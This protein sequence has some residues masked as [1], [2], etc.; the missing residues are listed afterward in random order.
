MNIV[1]ENRENLTALITVTVSEADYTEAVDKT[2]REYKRKANIP[3]FRPGMVPMG[4]INK[5][6]RRGAVAEESYKIANKACFDFIEKEKIDFVGD[7]LPSDEQKPF[8]FDNDKEHEFKFELGLAPEVNIALSEKDKINFLKITVSD[9][10]R[11][12]FRTNY[13]RRFG[14]LEDVESV[15]GDEAL[16]VTLDNGTVKVE[17]AYVGLVSMGEAERSLFA[18]RK[19]GDQMDVD[20]N[21]LYTN[22]AQRAAILRV[23]EDE[24]EGIDPKFKLTIEKIRRFVEP[25][26]NEEFFKMAFPGGEVSDEKGFAAFVDGQISMDLNRESEW[27][28][29]EQ[30]KKMLLDKAALKMPAEFLKK[31]LFTIN[32]G[33]FSMEDIEKDFDAFLQM[34]TWN[35]IQKHYVDTLELKLTEEEVQAEAKALAAMQFAQYGMPQVPEDMLANYAE[36]ILS[37]REEARKITEKLYEAKVIGAVRPMIGVKEKKVSAEEFG[38]AV[39]KFSK[40]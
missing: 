11:N 36:R 40:Q 32:E 23:K 38:K 5:M 29:S 39:E 28:F 30:V 31:W 1:R 13:M 4:I 9:E 27:F 15:E 22:P 14:R 24:L 20:L 2:L 7:V 12:N 10:M 33:K 21:E 16:T 34:M 37:N 25:E 26:L 19:K 35:R 17:E 3:G 18:G 6:Y 8:D